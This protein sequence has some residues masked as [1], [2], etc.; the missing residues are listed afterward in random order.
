[1]KLKE[2]TNREFFNPS[3][4]TY[5]LFDNLFRVV[6]LRAELMEVTYNTLIKLNLLEKNLDMVE[7]LETT[8]KDYINNDRNLKKSE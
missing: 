4:I 3:E 5:Y 2:G 7:H 8:K 6:S 1:M